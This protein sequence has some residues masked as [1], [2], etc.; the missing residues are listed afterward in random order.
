MRNEVREKVL[1]ALEA[2]RDEGVSDVNFYAKDEN[3][4][5]IVKV[6]MENVYSVWNISDEDDDEEAQ[7]ILKETCEYCRKDAEL[8]VGKYKFHGSDFCPEVKK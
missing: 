4:N 7:Y 1:A 6:E 5:Y 3:G 8:T 2:L